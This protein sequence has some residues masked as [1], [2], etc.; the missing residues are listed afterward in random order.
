MC[1]YCARSPPTH[2]ATLHTTIPFLLTALQDNYYSW[3]TRES[4]SRERGR[5]LQ[6]PTKLTLAGENCSRTSDGSAQ[7]D[8]LKSHYL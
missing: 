3:A 7:K 4:E 1:Y 6:S 5:H 2:T 8:K